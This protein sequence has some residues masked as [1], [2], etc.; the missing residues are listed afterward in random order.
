MTINKHDIIYQN[1]L[2]VENAMT[3]VNKSKDK[4]LALEKQYN[5]Q[6]D[7]SLWQKIKTLKREHMENEKHLEICMYSYKQAISIEQNT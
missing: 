7:E 4:I 5:S 2:I 1:R 6:K 3:L